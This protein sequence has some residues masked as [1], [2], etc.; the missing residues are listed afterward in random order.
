MQY[1]ITKSVTEPQNLKPNTE[2]NIFI[3]Q[4]IQY[5]QFLKILDK[6]IQKE[7][8]AKDYCKNKD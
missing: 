6:P 3:F 7:N 2:V 8:K 1:K 5:K 4:H